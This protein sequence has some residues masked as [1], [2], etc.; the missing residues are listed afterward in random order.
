M[1][2]IIKLHLAFIILM[3]I[4]FLIYISPI[5]IL[6]CY[7]WYNP[8]QISTLKEYADT[9]PIII[10]LSSGVFCIYITV[11]CKLEPKIVLPKLRRLMAIK[12]TIQ[13]D[14]YKLPFIIRLILMVLI[15]CCIAL[16]MSYFILTTQLLIAGI[17]AIGVV[18]VITIMSTLCCTMM[19][20][21]GNW[22]LPF[23]EYLVSLINLKK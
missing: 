11:I 4:D 13:F 20:Y 19:Y 14:K 8:Q 5:C 9:H 22:M 10:A 3:F 7:L 21:I 23:V 16:V 12:H 17:N 18:L 2:Q 6:F 1:K 15:Y